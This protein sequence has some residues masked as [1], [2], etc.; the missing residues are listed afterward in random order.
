MKL[1]PQKNIGTF[2]RVLRLAIAVF[3]IMY[4]ILAT[5][6]I[7]VMIVLGILALFCVY[8]AIAGWC[9]W[10]Q[11]IGKNTCPVSDSDRV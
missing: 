10:Y 8:Q 3:I 9:L 11:I 7:L 5:H 4:M 2:D 6:T 1:F